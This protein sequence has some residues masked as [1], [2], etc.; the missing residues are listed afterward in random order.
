MDAGKDALNARLFQP[1][2]AME[3][4]GKHRTIIGQNRIVPVLK[5]IGLVDLD[6]LAEDAAAIDS[7]SHCP[8]DAAVAMISAAVAV[9][10][11]SAPELGDH[12]HHG[13]PPSRRSD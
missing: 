2:H 5:K 11:E 7:A 13:I 9:L 4:A 3:Q 1:E 6:L 8:V 12:H 10:P